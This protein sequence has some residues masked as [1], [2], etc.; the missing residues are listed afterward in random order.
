MAFRKF[1]DYREGTKRNINWFAGATLIFAFKF[2][3][4]WRFSRV[5]IDRWIREQS[6]VAMKGGG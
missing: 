4:S 3:G 6:E 1:A 5:D 2:G